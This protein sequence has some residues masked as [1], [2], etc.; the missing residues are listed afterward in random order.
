MWLKTN[1]AFLIILGTV[2][3]VDTRAQVILNEPVWVG[4]EQ[5]LPTNDVRS[6]RKDSQ[7]FI[8]LGTAEGLC[9]FDGMEI[10]VFKPSAYRPAVTADNMVLSVLPVEKRIW[11][12]TNYGVFVLDT[13]TE[14]FHHY[15]IIEKGKEDSITGGFYQM[16][17]V[18]YRDRQG[19]I[20]IGT[21][22]RG[23]WRY[24]AAQDAFRKISYPAHEFPELTPSLGS[25][26]SVLSII[27]S[28][29]NDS[30]I[31]AGTV[32][33]L[34][35][36]NKYTGR[37]H[38]YT[39]PKPEKSYQ[40]G[41]N[42][43]RRLYHHDDGL[44]YVGSWTAGVNVF[45]PVK[46]TFTPLGLSQ[47]GGIKAIKGT[48]TNLLRK[49][50]DE[51]WITTSNGLTVYNTKRN[52]ITW[53]WEN[54]LL[55]NRFFG[56]DYMDESGR[57]WHN[58][59][60]GLL[61][62]DPVTQQFSQYSYEHLFDKGWSFAFYIKSDPAGNIITVC[63]RVC[64]GLFRYDRVSRQWT[65]FPFTELPSLGYETLVVRGFEETEPGNYI[66]STD[67]GLYVYSTHRRRLAKAPNQPPAAFNRWGEILKS[68]DGH[69][70]LSADADGLVKWDFRKGT[71]R[72]FKKE[73]T[74]D[75]SGV[76]FIRPDH[77]FEDS[78]GNIW[79]SRADGFSVYLRSKDSILNFI[80]AENSL[81][82]IPVIQGIA[83]DRDGRIWVPG[84]NGWYGYI[85]ARYPEKGIARKFN[86]LDR[87]INGF[88]QGFATDKEGNVW[89]YT[90]T[91]LVRINSADTSVSTF[92]IDYG[93][94][95]PDF[96]HFSF[97]PGGEM[98]FGGRNSIILADIG[99]LRRNRELPAPYISELR[100][101]NKPAS[102]QGNEEPLRLRYR[103]NFIT[104]HFSA[105]AFTMPQAVRFRYR[106]KNFDDW[107]E[108]SASR[109]ANYTNIP[110]GNYV[111]ELQAA[112][113]E[114]MWNSD[115]LRVPV[116]IARPWYL[117]WWFR[118]GVVL[119]VAALI[120][121]LYRYRVDQVRRK[122]QL[123]SQYEKKL[124]NVEMTALLS[125]MNPHFL[126]NSLNSIDSYII[127]NESGK[128][129]EYLN[130][131]ARLMRLI[132]QNSRSNYISLKDELEALDLYLQMEALRFRD[133]FAYTIQ[134]DDE[135]D[136]ASIVIPPMLIQPYVE[137][138]IW[139]GLMHKHDGSPG[140]VSIR[141][142]RRGNNLVCVVE[143][144]GI[145][146]AKAA[147]LKAQ[148]PGNPKRSMGMQITADRIEMINKLYNTKT[149]VQVID[150][151]DEN[152]GGTGTRVE[153][154]IPF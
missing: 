107:V 77:L 104:F 38:W 22:N 125:Q 151:R 54:E 50:A 14:T 5:G 92:N 84:R 8:W 62:Y 141:I 111:F 85:N 60:R 6:I 119:L 47:S 27:Q 64:D 109:M 113:N 4:K 98:I 146:R 44:L 36:I 72:V 129:S 67:R 26:N 74:P 13:E 133:K 101:L 120:Y 100:L 140:Q 134:A 75:G 68:A 94:K 17:T 144:N 93:V 66:I 108:G 41:L 35:E 3:G 90:N 147:S 43:F 33:G 102:L 21:R 58:T 9:R 56:I 86:L 30:L 122:E 121:W 70:W 131:F 114:G 42:A 25:R 24:D 34:Q 2:F 118:I 63:P 117:T 87:G 124:A 110:P 80:S 152:G 71:S 115:I 12:A 136:T 143:D 130:N 135:L 149:S 137:N 116:K 139:H 37:V 18:L 112:N 78:R 89:G 15:P 81:N 123:R 65:K 61:Y 28:A 105:R 145:G 154:V 148:R 59:V 128:A 53:F 20:W 103:Q 95:D 106:L 96:F 79:F 32:S 142:S 82:S 39:F 31:W 83:E 73:L 49:S 126:F 16:V 57:I 1:I 99:G 88:I 153:L 48:I 10:K 23:M 29:A 45:D 132:L 40:V 7:G 11:A 127:K 51:I 52:R 55:T 91:Y 97:L 138:A 46:K 150:L 69:L 76:G 19:D